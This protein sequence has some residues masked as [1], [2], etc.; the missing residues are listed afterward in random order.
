MTLPSAKHT[1]KTARLR[2]SRANDEKIELSGG[3]VYGD[4][5][6]QNMEERLM[7]AK[8]PSDAMSPFRVLSCVR[9]SENGY[10]LTNNTI[11][12]QIRENDGQAL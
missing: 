6:S 9:T 10:L 7:K 12:K 11:P 2:E 4:L 1:I 5:G 3:N 8:S